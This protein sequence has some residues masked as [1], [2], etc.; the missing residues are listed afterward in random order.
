MDLQEAGVA[1]PSWTTLKGELVIRCA[2]V[3]HRTTRSD[4]DLFLEAIGNLA[5]ARLKTVVD[6]RDRPTSL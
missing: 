2:I 6:Q 4:I 5:R 3:N 1:A